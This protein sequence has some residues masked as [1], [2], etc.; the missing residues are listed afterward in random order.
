MGPSGQRGLDFNSFA[1][2]DP[3]APLPDETGGELSQ[4]RIGSDINRLNEAAAAFAIT[5]TV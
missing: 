5:W 2:L 1:Y 4:H 3:N